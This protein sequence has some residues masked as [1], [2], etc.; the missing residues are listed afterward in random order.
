MVNLAPSIVHSSNFYLNRVFLRLTC[1]PA[2]R[3]TASYLT[4]IGYSLA[5][6]ANNN[7]HLQRNNFRNSNSFPAVEKPVAVSV[8]R[9]K[10]HNEG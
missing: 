6:Q 8:I 10:G 2:T 3:P 5:G 7:I 1:Q 4:Q 9:S